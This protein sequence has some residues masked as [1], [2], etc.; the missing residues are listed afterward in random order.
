MKSTQSTSLP[1]GL[2]L[3][4]G[5]LEETDIINNSFNQFFKEFTENTIKYFI[6]ATDSESSS[7]EEG[8]IRKITEDSDEETGE[9]LGVDSD[10]FL[11]FFKKDISNIALHIEEYPESLQPAFWEEVPS[12]QVEFFKTCLNKNA[13]EIN[14]IMDS[15]SK[16]DLEG[17]YKMISYCLMISISIEDSAAAEIFLNDIP[18]FNKDTYPNY[19]NCITAKLLLCIAAREKTNDT[20]VSEIEALINTLIDKGANINQPIPDF[21]DNTYSYIFSEM[22]EAEFDTKEPDTRETDTEE[23]HHHY[24]P[25]RIFSEDFL[26]SILGFIEDVNTLNYS[27]F[28][29][30]VNNVYVGKYIQKTESAL[31]IA[32]EAKYL[33]LAKELI[34]RGADINYSLCRG[35]HQYA[36]QE[37]V[38]SYA[39]NSGPEYIELLLNSNQKIEKPIEIY[40]SMISCTRYNL[41]GSVKEY[42]YN[43]EYILKMLLDDQNL[44]S[45]SLSKLLI[46]AIDTQRFDLSKALMEHGADVNLVENGFVDY[47][48]VLDSAKKAGPEYIKLAFEN[49]GMSEAK[50]MMFHKMLREHSWHQNY[51]AELIISVV[52]YVNLNADIGNNGDT[53]LITA[54]ATKNIDIIKT[55]IKHGVDINKP[56]IYGNYIKLPVIEAACA[57]V[58]FLKSLLE[59]GQEAKVGYEHIRAEEKAK[60][61][62]SVSIINHNTEQPIITIPNR[63]QYIDIKDIIA[64]LQAQIK[65]EQ[66]LNGYIDAANQNEF[67]NVNSLYQAY[68]AISN[69]KI[70]CFQSFGLLANEIRENSD[71]SDSSLKFNLMSAI[72]T[73]IYTSPLKAFHICKKALIWPSEEPD[74]NTDQPL[75]IPNDIWS[76]ICE[77][78]IKEFQSELSSAKEP[79]IE[80][81]LGDAE[82]DH[83]LEGA[84]EDSILGEAGADSVFGGVDGW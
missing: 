32:I 81:I 51:T 63:Y 9:I 74:E 38:I 35:L 11:S 44:N 59:S 7:L 25:E 37:S 66:N 52:P 15:A 79:G 41:D 58:E 3:P 56:S 83:D 33:R 75:Y 23:A 17:Y 70:L 42:V 27:K 64:L 21:E 49:G 55:M 77:F 22:I 46:K 26:L 80:S 53:L 28:E 82:A 47:A 8:S 57:G 16:K 29:S 68:L 72:L 30:Y 12:K 67:T 61:I 31:M 76:Y 10:E 45:N 19:Y 2:L 5:P 36:T 62:N 43:E 69:T 20:S 34:D 40:E 13:E 60:N 39:I 78:I 48:P 65:F 84:G 73:K 4:K 6:K 71:I 14:T 50:D 1:E 24:K 54:I 18:A